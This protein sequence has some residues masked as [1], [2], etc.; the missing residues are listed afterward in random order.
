[1]KHVTLRISVGASICCS[2]IDL[3]S[4]TRNLAHSGTTVAWAAIFQNG[5]IVTWGHSTVHFRSWI[6][7]LC[8]TFGALSEPSLN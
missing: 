5:D 3:V 1:M 8:L 7:R 2:G 4:H 6:L